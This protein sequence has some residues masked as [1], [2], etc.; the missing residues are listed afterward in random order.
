MNR[1]Q[2]D[3]KGQGLV[4]YALLLVLVAVVVV[5][6]LAVLGPQVG[7]VFSQVT[8]SMGV[9]ASGNGGGGGTGTITSASFQVRGGDTVVVTVTVSDNPTTITLSDSQG[10]A[11]VTVS[12]PGAC[13][14]SITVGGD[15]DGV[16]T[17]TAANTVQVNYPSD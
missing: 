5:G 14:P 13:Q 16:I 15:D 9:V 10:G 17:V 4:E 2:M 11:D 3:T 7:N 8:N 1:L 12:C 6:I